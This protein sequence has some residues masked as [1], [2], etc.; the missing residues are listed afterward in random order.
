MRPLPDELVRSARED[1]HYLLHAHQRLK[2]EMA[3]ASPMAHGSHGPGAHGLA[4][5]VWQRP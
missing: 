2:R 5:L 3:I 4:S 1:T